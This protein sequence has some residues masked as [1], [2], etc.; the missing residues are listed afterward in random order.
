MSP[1]SYEGFWH[2]ELSLRLGDWTLAEDLRHWVNDGVMTFFFFV[3]GL[4]I[5]RELDMGELREPPPLRAETR[6]PAWVAPGV[7]LTVRGWADAGERVELRANG[8]RLAGTTAGRLG[9]FTLRA[10]APARA[11]RYALALWAPTRRAPLAPLVVRPVVLAAGAPRS[12]TAHSRL[13]TA[14]SAA[15]PARSAP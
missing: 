14:R 6:L 1:S 9:G 4:E 3:V 11:G 5:R 10:A 15:R 7:E 8:I 2:T 12:E 13:T